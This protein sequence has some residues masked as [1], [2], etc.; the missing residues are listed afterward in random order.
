MDVDLEKTTFDGDLNLFMRIIQETDTISLNS[1]NLEILECKIESIDGIYESK[2]ILI[3]NN[4]QMVTFRFPYT[5]KLGEAILKI[6]FAGKLN[7][8][9]NGFYKSYYTAPNGEKRVMATT[10]FEPI[11]ARKA[12][13]CFDEPNRKANFEITLII[14]SDRIAI[15]N[16]P[17]MNEFVRKSDNKKVVSFHKTPKMR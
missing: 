4:N 11:E 8:K 16:T 10:Q 7:D 6:K 13:P 9:L 17:I 12:F 5:L 2:E 14:P 3:D 15:S 1:L